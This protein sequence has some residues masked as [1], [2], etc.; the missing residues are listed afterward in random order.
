MYQCR[1]DDFKI[2]INS[3]TQV[4]RMLKH[5]SFSNSTRGWHISKWL[6]FIHYFL[7]LFENVPEYKKLFFNK[8]SSYQYLFI[9]IQVPLSFK[10]IA[11]KL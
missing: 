8:T 3:V 2:S 7:S 10:E 9:V 6:L 5:F 1:D 11:I 4:D